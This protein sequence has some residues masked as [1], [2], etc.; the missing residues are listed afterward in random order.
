MLNGQSFFLIARGPEETDQRQSL[1]IFVSVDC[2]FICENRRRC[3][4]TGRVSDLL[5]QVR[6]VKIFANALEGEEVKRLV[7]LEWT[8]NGRAVLLAMKAIERFAVGSVCRQSLE[9]LEVK[10]AAVN[11]VRT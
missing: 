3:D 4:R 10:R 8:T 6:A 7:F 2:S 5:T 11:V 1:A 9:T